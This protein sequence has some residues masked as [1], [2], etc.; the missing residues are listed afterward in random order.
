MT[1]KQR[2]DCISGV[3]ANREKADK[4][5]SH[6]LIHGLLDR[7]DDPEELAEILEAELKD[8]DGTDKQ[9]ARLRQSRRG[10]II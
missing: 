7:V 6:E 2:R 1:R 10:P 4:R 9:V 3:I 8:I 5:R